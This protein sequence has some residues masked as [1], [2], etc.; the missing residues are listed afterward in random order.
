MGYLVAPSKVSLKN[1]LEVANTIFDAT[2]ND[3]LNEFREACNVPYECGTYRA[4][5]T[6]L[7]RFAATLLETF[8]FNLAISHN[9]SI[10][11][12][13]AIGYLGLQVLH[14]H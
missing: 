11:W 6:D 10:E 12:I 4:T 14:R 5:N 2:F 9:F 3:D 8:Y 1:V 13:F 7:L